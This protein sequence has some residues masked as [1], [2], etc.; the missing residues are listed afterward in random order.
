MDQRHTKTGKPALEL[1][2]EAIHLLRC[3][4]PATLAVYYAG[5]VPFVLGFLF[6][7]TD[8]SR[9]PFA[10]G[11]LA[12]TALGT[13]AL[14]IW[15]KIWQVAF[16]ERV[17]AQIAG[18]APGPWTLRD[19]LRIFIV[20]TVI[21]PTGLFLVPL[22]LTVMVPSA[23]VCAFYQ[24]VT[25]ADAPRSGDVRSV[26]RKAI[27]Q[28]R[29]W[30]LQNHY[31]LG[32]MTLFGFC[33]FLNWLIVCFSVPRLIKMLFGI[34]S[35]FTLDA[36]SMLNTTFLAVVCAL[37]YLSVDPILK[38]VYAVRCFYGDSLRSGEDLKAS[39][40]P[41]AHRVALVLI[42]G[43]LA[44]PASTIG[45]LYA[46][47]ARLQT[48]ATV[49][50]AE[51]DKQIDEVIH[52]RKYAWRLPRTVQ[53]EQTQKGIVSRFLDD[54]AG[55]M[56]RG[57]RSFLTWLQRLAR[58]PNRDPST[59]TPF[60]W[61][62]SS[63]LLYVLI[64]VVLALLIIFIRR[65]LA[66]RSP[67][68]IEVR[69]EAIRYAPDLADENIGADQLPGDAWIELAHDLIGRGEFRLALRALYLS[70]LAHL[71]QR[72]LIVLAKF[73]SNREYE[74]ELRRRAHALPDLLPIFA[75]NVSTFERIWYGMHDVNDQLV[76]SFA[77]NV[78][79]ISALQ[80]Q[81]PS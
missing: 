40:K 66:Q 57:I 54:V 50:G 46:L 62:S 9:N 81:Q 65:V 25:A 24:N 1:I 71:A 19:A 6:F 55:M 27:A 52:A 49:S 63:L 76:R 12:E 33:V 35:V 42:A 20:Q 14:F 77:A 74:H 51:L 75:E 44:V 17:R 61:V 64:A 58:N 38:A 30:P 26:I 4:P 56:K 15:M 23:W 60:D 41:F 11:H 7:W 34:E 32:S 79:R 37:T 10:D 69:A 29:L 73:K 68:R 80:P 53:E 22:A 31:L 59:A 2:E 3:A 28:T 16:A 47:P 39:L 36:G 70:N 18:G 43:A 48:A 13:A 5:A 78:E 45:A 72:K 21:Q 67:T 8:M